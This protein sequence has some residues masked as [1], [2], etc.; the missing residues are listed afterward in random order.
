MTPLPP[1]S[2]LAELTPADHVYDLGCGDG[3][4]LI[5]AA[6]DYGVTAVGIDVD[7]DL[8]ATARTKAE[9]A[10]V[11]QQLQFFRKRSV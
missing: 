11:G 7:A 1:C 5:Q 9:A 8:L 6:L 2:K 10:G 3:R 4:L